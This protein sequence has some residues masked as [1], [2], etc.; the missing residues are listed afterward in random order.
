MNLPFDESKYDRFVEGGIV[1]YKPKKHFAHN[2]PSRTLSPNVNST[3]AN[4]SNNPIHVNPHLTLL[5]SNSDPHAQHFPS[6][7]FL[8]SSNLRSLPTQQRAK[9]LSVQSA[10]RFNKIP[11]SFPQKREQP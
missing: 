3:H 2:L 8:N 6:P 1:V 9:S 10:S 11:I 4:L 5:H 7:N